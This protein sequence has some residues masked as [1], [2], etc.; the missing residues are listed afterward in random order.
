MKDKNKIY[1]KGW[2]KNW[3]NQCYSSRKK[4]HKLDHFYDLSRVILMY[5]HSP[6][7]GLILDVGAGECKISSVLSRV[8]GKKVKIVAL[9]FSSTGLSKCKH[10]GFRGC[11]IM[12]DCH[13][14]PFRTDVFDTISCLE[15]IEHVGS[16]KLLIRSIRRALKENGTLILTT[17]NGNRIIRIMGR[18]LYRDIKI[19]YSHIH[20]FSIKEIAGILH[21]EKLKIVNSIGLSFDVPYPILVRM[22]DSIIRILLT[23]MKR[24]TPLVFFKFLGV[25]SKKI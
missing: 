10:R 25:I 9:D 23:L 14:L 6:P 18:L 1:Q 22:P 21:K 13:N 15:V 3:F 2:Q 16:P 8:L 12:G 20:E 11:L 4:P 24:K 17:P 5:K 7:Q 19:D